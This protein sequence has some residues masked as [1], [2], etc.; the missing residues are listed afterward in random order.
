MTEQSENRDILRVCIVVAIVLYLLRLSLS[1]P[2]VSH[3]QTPDE[4]YTLAINSYKKG[5]F[6]E[7]SGYLEEYVK[8]KPSPEAYYLLGYSY[9]KLKLFREAEKAFNEAYLIDPELVPPRITQE[10]KEVKDA[11]SGQ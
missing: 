1:V 3:A 11:D 8:I 5:N 4:L 2:E 10:D 6:K 7:A 9:Y